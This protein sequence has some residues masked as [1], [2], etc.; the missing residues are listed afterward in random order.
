VRRDAPSYGTR[1]DETG[2]AGFGVHLGYVVVIISTLAFVGVVIN[3]KESLGREVTELQDQLLEARVFA[4]SLGQKFASGISI[5]AF[6]SLKAS[7]ELETSMRQELET[8][9]GSEIASR[10]AAE[11]AL[12]AAKKTL[13]KNESR[14]GRLQSSIAA[15]GASAAKGDGSSDN[16]QASA[17]RRES[18]TI[19]RSSLTHDLSN[20]SPDSDSGAQLNGIPEL[21]ALKSDQVDDGEYLPISKVQ[22]QYPRRALS[23]GISGW[24]IVEFTVTALGTVT[25][26]FVISNCGWIKNA[27]N[28]GKC[29]DNPNSVFDSAATKAAEKFKYKPKVIDGES[30]ATASVQNKFSFELTED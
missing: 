1:S 28:Q 20:A 19:D 8:V 5:E 21:V 22:P 9:L 3:D 7:L 14:L 30:V 15:M 26:P 13:E 4:E 25:D 17:D 29:E 16:P 12:V 2:K 24:V 23:K 10:K 6:D 27:R 11:Q 18:D